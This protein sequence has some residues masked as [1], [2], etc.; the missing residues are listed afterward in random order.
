MKKIIFVFIFILATHGFTKPAVTNNTNDLVNE[1]SI[2]LNNVEKINS[3]NI[4][5]NL[6]SVVNNIEKFSEIEKLS[7]ADLDLTVSILKALV[8]IEPHDKSR[9]SAQMLASSYGSH[10]QI[11]QLALKKLSKSE[12][13]E[14]TEIFKML[15][16]LNSRGHG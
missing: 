15:E 5:D 16:H 3:K 11:Y 14:I 13:K 7:E 2:L 9:T 10:K 4:K 8:L 12:K 1:K 6:K